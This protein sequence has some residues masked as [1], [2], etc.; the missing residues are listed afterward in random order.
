MDAASDRDF[1]LD[2]LYACSLLMMHASRLAEDWILYS[3][4]EFQWMTLGDEV[5]SGS[6]LMP[7]KKNPD[8]LELVRGKT[9]RVFGDLTS[10]FVTM[11][12]LPMTYNRDMQ[13]DK[14]PLFDAFHQTSGSLEMLKAVAKSVTLNPAK[15]STMA[16]ESWVIATDLAEELARS[17]VAFHR[18]HQI[19][20]QLVLES[21]R[22][23]KKPSDWSGEALASFAPEFKPEMARLFSPM[24]GM[25]SRELHGG[26]GPAAVAR[27]VEEAES[28]LAVLRGRLRSES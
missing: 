18:A 28:R 9:G 4:E 15:A 23:Q 7:Q 24:E 27:A 10:L 20:G 8:S 17:G 21:L 1:A 16:E 11:K 5:T 13:E 2:F 22:A 25:K 6:S 14:Q 19:A 12:G 3:S 26:T